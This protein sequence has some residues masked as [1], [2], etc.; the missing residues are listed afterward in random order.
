MNAFLRFGATMALLACAGHGSAS[1]QQSP[2]GSAAP[3]QLIGGPIAP[4]VFVSAHRQ[5]EGGSTLRIR[6]GEQEWSVS[7]PYQTI[8]AA[9]SLVD[10]ILVA[11]ILPDQRMEHRRLTWNSG[12]WVA[13]GTGAHPRGAHVVRMSWGDGRLAML[14]ADGAIVSAPCLAA[15]DVPTGGDFELV[16]S[17]PP[18][19]VRTIRTAGLEVVEEGRIEVYLHPSNRHAFVR[20][21]AGGWIS[22]RVD[23]AR[24]AFLEVEKPARAGNDVRYFATARGPVVL[25]EEGT[26]AWWPVANEVPASG[27]GVVPRE[28][29]AL[30][31]ADRRYRLK[32]H[33]VTGSWFHPAA[34]EG[35]AWGT[36][37]LD[38]QEC[39]VH[40]SGVRVEHG[41]MIA[42]TIL[43]F[44]HEPDVTTV[45]KV[46]FVAATAE[47]A[48]PTTIR[49]GH[50]WLVPDRALMAEKALASKRR[51]Y[52]LAVPVPIPSDP[53]CVGRWIHV[54][55]VVV[56]ANGTVLG[57][58][59]VRSVRI[60]PNRGTWPLAREEAARRSAA[61][62]WAS[63]G[64]ENP[65]EFWQFLVGQ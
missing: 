10:D 14:L 11:G 38:L 12:R 37:G 30:L 51:T 48:P 53:I 18:G 24:S 47:A 59:G 19:V 54:Q 15:Q 50:T 20:Q 25:E 1:S 6:S 63:H 62:C 36:G 58:T 23:R 16:G 5:P 17:A 61:A 8:T 44:P 52:A 33:D 46:A 34:I 22:T 45:F 49:N 2:T 32:A 40:E 26:A 42:G 4:G 41:S 55:I 7:L 60:L 28:L 65:L 27:Q 43:H 13:S 56:A 64:V 39:H 29:S 3:Q 21:P 9:T 57:A 31:H 35:V